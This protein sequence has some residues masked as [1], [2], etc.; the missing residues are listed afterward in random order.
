METAITTTELTEEQ[1]RVHSY[2]TSQ[3]E[4]YTWL[5]LWVKVLGPR[6]QLIETL[7]GLTE[8]QAGARTSADEWTILEALRHEIAVT[9]STLHTIE[10]LTGVTVSDSSQEL[11]P[12]G[13]SFAELR[14]ELILNGTQ[15]GTLAATLPE[16]VPIN[17]TVPH[18]NFGE[19]HCRAWYIFQR[20]HDV[21]HVTQFRAIRA[22]PDFPAA[23]RA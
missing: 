6:L 22:A 16:D 2:L 7:D 23:N 20:I 17:E 15:F 11:D 18:G 5:D 8:S 4:K 12:A 19:L 1:Q 3:G 21:D 13:L 14:R 9:R 10:R